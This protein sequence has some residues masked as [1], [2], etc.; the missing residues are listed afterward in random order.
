[1]FGIEGRDGG[2]FHKREGVMFHRCLLEAFGRGGRRKGRKGWRGLSSSP[3][4]GDSEEK[5]L[6]AFLE[7]LLVLLGTASF[8]LNPQEDF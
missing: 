1:M 8:P 2:G 6:K 7:I 4:V 5:S 3:D